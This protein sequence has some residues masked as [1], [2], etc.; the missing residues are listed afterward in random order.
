MYRC[1]AIQDKAA[2]TKDFFLSQ[3]EVVETIELC[4]AMFGE[5][6]IFASTP[7]DSF[8]YEL[9]AGIQKDPGHFFVAGSLYKNGWP[10]NEKMLNRPVR[11]AKTLCDLSLQFLRIKFPDYHWR[12]AWRCFDCNPCTRLPMAVRLDKIE[13]FSEKRGCLPNPS[14]ISIWRSFFGC[15]CVIQGNS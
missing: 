12:A 6:R 3:E 11:F 8:T 4:I 9:L 15:R 7:N 13:Q 5:G 10:T 1:C 2:D 14:Q